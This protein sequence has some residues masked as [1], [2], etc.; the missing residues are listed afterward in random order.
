MRRIPS[1]HACHKLSFPHSLLLP[2]ADLLTADCL[3]LFT[4]SVRNLHDRWAKDCATYRELY[5]QVQDLELTQK[6]DWGPVL[7]EKL[8]S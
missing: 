6:I 1:R 2:S 8:V 7:D 4:L 5:D 3:I